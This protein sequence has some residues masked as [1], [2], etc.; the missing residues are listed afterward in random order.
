MVSGT[1][2]EYLGNHMVESWS[3]RLD[4]PHPPGPDK[5][6]LIRLEDAAHLR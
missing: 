1:T 6:G 5:M 4:A 2:D 3:I